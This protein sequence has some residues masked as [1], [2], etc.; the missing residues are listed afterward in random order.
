[1]L[2]Q[3][4]FMKK[5]LILFL[6]L[7]INNIVFSQTSTPNWG[8]FQFN[9]NE[10]KVS[11]VK[12]FEIDPNLKLKELKIFF[13]E[14]NL[15]EFQSEDS[16][17]LFG[18]FKKRS[19]DIQKYGYKRGNTPMVLLDVE[20]VC[21]VKIEYKEG[22]YRVTLTELGYIDNGVI[23]DIWMKGLFGQELPTSKGNFV[24][25]DG[26]LTFTRTNEVRKTYSTVYEVL[27]KFYTDIFTYKKQ[28]KKV[29]NW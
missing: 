27:E 1:M 23:S 17:S 7:L 11:W 24:S 6:L 26:E 25:Y 13:I 5:L 19:I 16:V 21:N 9:T 18:V 2:K 10:R 29:D 28:T 8:S 22:R 14:N 20:Q 4:Y 12:V 15:V 3:N